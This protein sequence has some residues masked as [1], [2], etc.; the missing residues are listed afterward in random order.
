MGMLDS[1]LG[2][3]LG[4]A[5][6]NASPLQSILGSL[7]G[8]G[9]QQRSQPVGQQG[10]GLGD[11]IN[12]FQQAGLGNVVN[13]WVGRGANQPVNPHQLQD[14]F[15]RERVDQWSQQTGIPQ[16]D[17]LNQLSQYLP[18]AVDRM[19]PEGQLPSAGPGSPFD[20]PGMEMPRRG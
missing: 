20:D 15:G 8:G 9:Q 14:V 16:N 19:T 11:L 4:G 2:S 3:L 1:V 17:L 10:G 12:M 18:H 6:G 7:L 5:G 13:S